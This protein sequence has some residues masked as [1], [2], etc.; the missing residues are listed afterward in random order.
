MPS[1]CSS[2]SISASAASRRCAALEIASSETRGGGARSTPERLN[3]CTVASLSK[4]IS[5]S[6][7]PLVSELYMLL[8]IPRC[9]M[10]A[11]N[12]RS[13]SCE[14]S[15]AGRW[16]F[17]VPDIAESSCSPPSSPAP[18]NRRWTKSFLVMRPNALGHM[19]FRGAE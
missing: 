4:A 8:S 18:R 17:E 2:C 11:R 5:L 3:S 1:A 10:R 19:L 12:M 7:W 9:S 13:A 14:S 15:T 6:N 16:S